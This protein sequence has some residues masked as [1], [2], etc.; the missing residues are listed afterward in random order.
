[1]ECETAKRKPKVSRLK[2][3]MDATFPGR[4]HWVNTEVPPSSTIV[5]KFPALKLLR[6]VTLGTCSII[7]TSAYMVFNAEGPVRMDLY[8][9][10]S[11]TCLVSQFSPSPKGCVL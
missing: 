8:Y 10:W 11:G 4:R 9:L 3:L 1:M 7:T 2:P 6:L 5:E